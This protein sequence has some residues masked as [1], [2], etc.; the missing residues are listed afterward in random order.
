MDISID[1]SMDI[2]MDI[3]IDIS[4]GPSTLPSGPPGPLP[5]TLLSSVLGG[6]CSVQH[7]TNDQHTTLASSMDYMFALLMWHS[8][9]HACCLDTTCREVTIHGMPS[10][11]LGG[12]GS[13]PGP[14]HYR[15]VCW[16]A[17][18][19]TLSLKYA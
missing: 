1:I 16:A 12:Q 14:A 18:H 15:V 3:S 5:S 6:V 17:Q 8:G 2:S 13:G 9:T 11:V 19:T 4:N 10:S 7:T